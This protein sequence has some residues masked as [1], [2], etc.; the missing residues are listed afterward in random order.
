[1][2]YKDILCPV[3]FSEG[4]DA[5]LRRAMALATGPGARVTLMHVLSTVAFVPYEG[6]MDPRITS[7]LLSSA[8]SQLKAWVERAQKLG[9]A[10]IESIF[11]QGAAWDR[12]VA[13]ARERH[14]EVIVMGTHGRTGLRHVL[15]GSVA[16]RVVRHAPCEVLVVRTP[17]SP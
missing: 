5:A 13:V 14:P 6:V 3:D 12:I 2:G 10:R 4:S 16:E 1:M 17:A 15:I 9:S 8:E 11:V 7:E